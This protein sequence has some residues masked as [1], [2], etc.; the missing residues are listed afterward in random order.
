MKSLALRLSIAFAVVG[1]VCAG[2][3]TQAKERAIEVADEIVEDE[4]I[5][6]LEQRLSREEKEER[7]KRRLREGTQLTDH[8]GHF[9]QDGDGAIFVAED[10]LEIV[11]LPNL[12]L[13]RVVRTLKGSDEAETI[14][15]SVTGVVT[16][17]NGRNFLLISRAV[18]KSASAPPAP[19]Q[20][21]V[22]N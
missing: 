5:R 14:R 19:E 6:Q 3:S 20:I 10:D 12:N 21:Q 8:G 15:W 4:A 9:R 13:E 16:E 22:M 7:A 17:F 2:W 11:A 18:Y 1:M